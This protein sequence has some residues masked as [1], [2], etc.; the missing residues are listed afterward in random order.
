MHITFKGKKDPGN[1]PG[2]MGPIAHDGVKVIRG[3]FLCSFSMWTETLTHYCTGYSLK[4]KTPVF[5]H[6]KKFKNGLPLEL[7]NMKRGIPNFGSATRSIYQ[8]LQT[9]SPLPWPR[10]KVCLDHEYFASEVIEDVP[11]FRTCES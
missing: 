1:T 11:L 8:K 7:M 6:P 4:T 9:V 2:F 10:L 3:D 5:V